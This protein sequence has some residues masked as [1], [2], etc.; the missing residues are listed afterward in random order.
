M[1]NSDLC[2]KNMGIERNHNS[3]TINLWEENFKKNIWAHKRKLNME[4]QNQWRIR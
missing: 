2:L 1:I 4:S 3:E